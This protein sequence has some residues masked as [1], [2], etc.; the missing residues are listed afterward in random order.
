MSS[1]TIKSP[2]P[3][4][5]ATRPSGE[6]EHRTT[7]RDELSRESRE[8]FYRDYREAVRAMRRGDPE[9]FNAYQSDPRIKP[10]P[11]SLKLPTRPNLQESPNGSELITAQVMAEAQFSVI[12]LLSSVREMV[13]SLGKLAEVFSRS[14]SK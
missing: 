6:S 4:R 1:M 14:L 11:E 9:R 7:D 2:L 3:R 8:H 10:C 13:T 5:E 12:S